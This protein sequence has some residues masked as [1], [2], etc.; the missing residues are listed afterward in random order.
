MV[1]S[2]PHSCSRSEQLRS[3]YPKSAENVRQEFPELVKSA[4][5]GAILNGV[6]FTALAPLALVFDT[7]AFFFFFFLEGQITEPST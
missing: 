4:K 3:L 1:L 7:L 5:K 2:A 6:I